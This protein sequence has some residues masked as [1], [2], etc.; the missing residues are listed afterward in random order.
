MASSTMLCDKLCHV[1]IMCPI[2]T[3]LHHVPYSTVNRAKIRTIWRPVVH[4]NEFK[5]FTLKELDHL[6]CTVCWHTVLPNTTIN[7]SQ[8]SVAARDDDSMKISLSSLD[9]PM[10]GLDLDQEELNLRWQD[11]RP[12]AE[13]ALSICR[14]YRSCWYA[15]KVAGDSSNSRMHWF[16]V[17]YLSHS[18]H[19]RRHSAAVLLIVCSLSCRLA[20][21]LHR[22]MVTSKNNRCHRTVNCQ[23]VC[24]RGTLNAVESIKISVAACIA[25]Y[26]VSLT[27]YGK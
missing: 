16:S 2:H 6:T 23:T 27:L 9:R 4:S 21:M 1:S 18:T 15:K 14:L 3:I 13:K 10:P 20:G 25:S 24:A 11:R 8:G 22:P 26:M 19:Q 12:I 17:T 7:V 5:S